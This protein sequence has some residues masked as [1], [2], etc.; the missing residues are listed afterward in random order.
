VSNQALLFA[1][2]VYLAITAKTITTSPSQRCSLAFLVPFVTVVSHASQIALMDSL[3]LK[4]FALIVLR[5]TTAE[6]VK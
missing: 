2:L 4:G 6:E 1:N 5:Q 3:K